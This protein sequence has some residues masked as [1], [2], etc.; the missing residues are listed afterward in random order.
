MSAAGRRP[1]PDQ[2]RDLDLPPR[3][4]SLLALLLYD[5]QAT[6]KELAAGLQ[7]ASTTVSL[8]VGDLSRQGILERREDERDRRRTIVT[9]ADA[10]TSAGEGWLAGGAES[11][12]KVLRPP[13]A[14]DRGVVVDALLAYERE[15][16]LA[17]SQPD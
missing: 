11:W 5:G 16:M 9:I 4:L 7:V 13:N 6:V 14:A 12:R 1:V 3:H 17:T 2:L 10:H 15:S 8:M